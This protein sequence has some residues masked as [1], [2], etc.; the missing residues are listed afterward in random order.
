MFFNPLKKNVIF[1][2]PGCTAIFRL[3]SIIVFVCRFV[4]DN[5]NSRIKAASLGSL[6]V[7][8]LRCH[9]AERHN[10]PGVPMLSL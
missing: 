4:L 3:Y 9:S 6:A 5:L 7:A 8:A 10:V 1:P 2:K